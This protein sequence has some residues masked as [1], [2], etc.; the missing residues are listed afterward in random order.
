MFR[1][2]AGNNR[3]TEST[4]TFGT[5]PTGT[6]GTERTGTDGDPGADPLGKSDRPRELGT[7]W[8]GR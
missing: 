4:G 3:A 1:P 2:F 6:F 8:W 5:A 7:S